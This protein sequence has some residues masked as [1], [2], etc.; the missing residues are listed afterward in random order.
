MFVRTLNGWMGAWMYELIL[1]FYPTYEKL[2]LP[3]ILFDV[4][5][6][7]RY[8]KRQKNASSILWNQGL[9]CE[10]KKYNNSTIT[11]I[12]DDSSQYSRGFSEP[13]HCCIQGEIS[14][15]FLGRSGLERTSRVSNTGVDWLPDWKRQFGLEPGDHACVAF[16]RLHCQFFCKFLDEFVTFCSKSSVCAK[17]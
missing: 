8:Q 6:I 15:R 17:N 13:C 2:I 7:I 5:Y 3:L 1:L 12:F 16:I 11:E 9:S 14:N 4:I 10:C